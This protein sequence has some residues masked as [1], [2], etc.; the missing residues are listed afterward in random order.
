[1]SVI[2]G[3]AFQTRSI[4]VWDLVVGD[5]VLLE[6]GSRVPADCL[7]LDQEGLRIEEI[8]DDAASGDRSEDEARANDDVFLRAGSMVKSGN[9]KALVC[10]VG[11]M[12]DEGKVELNKDTLLEKKLQNLGVQLSFF[13]IIATAVVAVELIIAYFIKVGT[14][15]GAFATFVAE[16]L[17]MVNFLVILAIA[18]IPEGLPLVIQLSLAFSIMTMYEQD[19]VLVKDLEA[20][21]TMGQ[22]EEILVG[23]TGTLTKA[24]M[25]V[26]HFVVE[27]ISRVNSRKNTILNC[28]VADY[29]LEKLKESILFNTT[30]RIET[31]ETSYVANGSPVDT[32]MINFLQDAD[33]PVHLMVQ[34]KFGGRL[35]AQRGFDQAHR[36]SAVC[37][38]N[39]DDD[40]LVT[41]Y[42]KGAPEE[43]IQ[44]CPQLQ[45]RDNEAP[46]EGHNGKSLKE[47][48]DFA[49][50]GYKVICY[51]FCEIAKDTW[52]QTIGG[53]AGQDE[54]KQEDVNQVF[55]EKVMDGESFTFRLLATFALKDGLRP[56]AASAVQYARDAAG[57]KVRLVS[58]DHIE[59]AT[60]TARKAG[61]LRAEDTGRAVMAGDDFDAAVGGITERSMYTDKDGNLHTYE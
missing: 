43:V 51:A 45:S 25:R 22:I 8:V 14:S 42:L 50:Q 9:A 49:M 7:I 34:R 48:N 20:P 54:W 40:Q 4:S 47:V 61:I 27:G 33:I 52:E 31:D 58:N 5:V 30:A 46:E 23:K 1:M 12:K 15:E 56:T 53:R 3:K 28:E 32:C 35:V 44:V 18:S 21:E 2:R 60:A 6:S 37:V 26:A 59:T 16:L 10:Q 55:A 57:L 24:K 17:K 11:T 36:T 13:A 39:F 19:H 38:E 29:N 41:V